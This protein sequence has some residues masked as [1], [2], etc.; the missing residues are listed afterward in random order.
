MP[1]EGAEQ[2][3]KMTAIYR[4]GCNFTQGRQVGVTAVVHKGSRKDGQL[5]KALTMMAVRPPARMAEVLAM[6]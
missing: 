3:V 6:N 1:P 5:I 2:R 4:T